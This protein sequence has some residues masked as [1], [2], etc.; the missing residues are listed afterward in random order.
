MTIRPAAD[1]GRTLYEY[2]LDATPIEPGEPGETACFLGLDDPFPPPEPA[3]ATVPS[4]KLKAWFD[5]Q[6]GT[7]IDDLLSCVPLSHRIVTRELVM[8]WATHLIQVA[9]TLDLRRLTSALLRRAAALPGRLV[10][11]LKR[12]RAVLT[13]G[14]DPA[15][16]FTTW[17]WRFFGVLMLVLVLAQTAL[18]TAAYAKGFGYFVPPPGDGIDFGGGASPP[19]WPAPP[20]GWGQPMI[21]QPFWGGG[22]VPG[23]GAFVNGPYYDPYYYYNRM[24]R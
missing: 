4:P 7:G 20:W 11:E 22:F 1:A 2:L 3:D 10:A 23:G 5:R 14:E 16:N 13:R 9:R 6:P 24:P 8:E 12:F 21:P 17:G 19:A 15:A 18:P